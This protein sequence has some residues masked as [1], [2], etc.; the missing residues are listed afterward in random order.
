MSGPLSS[1]QL[2]TGGLNSDENMAQ[3]SFDFLSAHRIQD[4]QS[5]LVHEKAVAYLRDHPEAIQEALQRLDRWDSR[6]P[7][8]RRP[9]H[10]MWRKI[11]SDRNWTLAVST[12]ELGN[13]LR[14]SSPLGLVL[15]EADR[16]EILKKIERIRNEIR[17][18]SAQ[19]K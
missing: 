17:Q 13:Q 12:S 2:Q 9:L 4:Y 8:V 11:L 5:L 6:E 15:P 3:F 19:A 18:Q 14:Q 1:K 16:A 7:K 10:E